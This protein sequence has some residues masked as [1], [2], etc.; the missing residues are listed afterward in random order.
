MIGMNVARLDGKGST[1]QH[2]SAH[3]F[4]GSRI[5]PDA[6]LTSVGAWFRI[7]VAI[8]VLLQLGIC[9]SSLPR[10]LAGLVDFRA[11]YTAGHLVATGHG[12]ELYSYPVQAATQAH[13]FAGHTQVLPFLYPACASLLFVP[14]SLLPYPIAFLVFACMN[15][16]LFYAVSR[17]IFGESSLFAAMH[18]LLRCGLL[19][20]FFPT[21]IVLMQGQISFLLLLFYG[22]CQKRVQQGSF[23][24]AGLF[25][26]GGMIKF[27]IALPVALVF[28]AWRN[29]RLIL[30]FLCGVSI[31]VLGSLAVCGR[32]GLTQYVVGVAH[33]TGT[34][35]RSPSAAKARYGMFAGDMPNLHGLIFTLTRGSSLVPVLTIAASAGLLFWCWRQRPSLYVALPAAMLVSYHMQAYDLVLLLLPLLHTAALLFQTQ[36]GLGEDGPGHTSDWRSW[37]SSVRCSF[38]FALLLLTI[39]VAPFLLVYDKSCFFAL[40][41]SAVLYCACS[42]TNGSSGPGEVA[43]S[44]HQGNKQLQFT[45]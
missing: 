26:S 45:H 33:I 16:A 40:G 34:T 29:Y 1:Q 19:A 13:L 41:V 35:L 15:L 10:S 39:P 11:F 31:L 37:K 32:S 12:T 42:L 14:L 9:W 28:L 22:L 38:I 23:F 6:A 44:G 20:A 4:S 30:G 17:I 27:Q 5:R 3:Q 2:H 24:M 36:P 7:G 8:L 18:P 21:S 43:F 25:L